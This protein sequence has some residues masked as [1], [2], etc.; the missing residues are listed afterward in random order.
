[1]TDETHTDDNRQWTQ[2]WLTRNEYFEWLDENVNEYECVRCG[3]ICSGE[4]V[5][6]RFGPV[7]EGCALQWSKSGKLQQRNLSSF[8]AADG[9]YRSNT[10]T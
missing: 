7:D 5:E 3:L 4:P 2:R 9:S 1:M 6:T 10:S 8:V